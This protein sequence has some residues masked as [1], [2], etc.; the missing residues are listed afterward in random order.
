MKQLDMVKAFAKLEGFDVHPDSNHPQ[1][2]IMCMVRVEGPYIK[3]EEYKPV[4]D[5]T[6]IMRYKVDIYHSL[7]CVHIDNNLNLKF[8]SYEEADIEMAI[9]ECI[10]KSKGLYDDRTT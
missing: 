10:L 5:V 8:V 4:I 7:S 1:T 3:W 9:I 6:I 2:H